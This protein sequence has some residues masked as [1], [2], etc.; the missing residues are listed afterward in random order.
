MGFGFLAACFWAT[1]GSVLNL[2]S[3][4]LTF[5]YAKLLSCTNM[6]NCRGT[7][8]SIDCPCVHWRCVPACRH[9]LFSRCM[10]DAESC[11]LVRIDLLMYNLVSFVGLQLYCLCTFY[12]GFLASVSTQGCTNE[13]QRG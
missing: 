7:C 9:T 3:Q 12:E 1:L 5:L 11:L 13:A 6:Q 10:C 4:V 8:C 2:M